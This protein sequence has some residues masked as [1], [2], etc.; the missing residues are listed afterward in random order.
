M[1][2]IRAIAEIILSAYR[3]VLIGSVVIALASLI[4]SNSFYRMLAVYLCL[5]GAIEFTGYFLGYVLKVSNHII[6]LLSAL[7]D[8]VFFLCLYKKFLFKRKNTVITIVAFLGILYVLAEIYLNFIY[9][10]VSIQEFQPYAK[11]VSNII[12]IVLSLTFLYEK[13]SS[14]TDARLGNFAFNNVVLIYFTLN[15]LI[16]LPFNFLVN[17][18][19]GVKFYFWGANIILILLFYVYLTTQICRNTFLK[20]KET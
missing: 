20:R 11:P 9:E 13:M 2:E 5:M 16:Y 15:T 12:I 3:Y 7:A 14:Y 8:L 10:R 18:N 4:K 1:D 17:E 6:V 19:S